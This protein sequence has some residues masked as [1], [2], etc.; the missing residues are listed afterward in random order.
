MYNVVTNLISILMYVFQGYFMQYLFSSFLKVKHEK[1]GMIGR[2]FIGLL[3]IFI[4]IVNFYVLPSQMKGQYFIVDVI[5]SIAFIFIFSLIWYKGFKSIKLFL[6]IVFITICELISFIAHF[7]LVCIGDFYGKAIGKAFESGKIP[8]LKACIAA[9]NIGMAVIQLF[10]T[11]AF[12]TLLYFTIKSITKNYFYKDH[13]LCK[14]ELLFILSPSVTYLLI[15]IFIKVIMVNVYGETNTLLYDKNP[16][17]FVL[18]PSI[19]IVSLCS[20][21]FGINLFQNVIR[22]N[23]EKRNRIIIEKQITN[24]QAHI[25]EIDSLYDGIRGMKHD[26]KNSI[27]VMKQ[28]MEKMGLDLS[29]KTLEINKYLVGMEQTINKLDFRFLTGNPVT[30]VVINDKYIEASKQIEGLEIEFDGFIFPSDL[31]IS[32]FDIGVIL[33]NALDNAIEACN[34]MKQKCTDIKTFIHLRSFRRGKLFFI[35]LEN[36]FDGELIF[37]EFSDLPVTSKREKDLHGIGLKNIRNSARKYHGDVDCIV[38]DKTFSLSVMLKE[39]K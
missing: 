11:I 7:I 31:Q 32:V 25:K 34:K 16:I 19:S 10:I 22:L 13:S 14:K 39:N 28:L 15:S 17:V 20:I 6:T 5:I 8:S 18:V 35:E 3:W 12:G 9:T 36:S 1:F 4:K 27:F 23:E 33:I 26:M 24:M 29:D 2:Y 37:D 30:D 21:I 38:N